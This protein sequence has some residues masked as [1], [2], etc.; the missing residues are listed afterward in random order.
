MHKSDTTNPR[1]AK[2]DVLVR[3]TIL[4]NPD[5]LLRLILEFLSFAEII[6]ILL[7]KNQ[8]PSAFHGVAIGASVLRH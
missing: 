1:Y 7:L 4:I 5:S 6:V 8:M 2:V 3:N